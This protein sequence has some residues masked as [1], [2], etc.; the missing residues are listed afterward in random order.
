MFH[1]LKKT[2]FFKRK[3]PS[4]ISIVSGGCKLSEDL[5]NFYLTDY[6]L[7][8]HEGYGLTEASPICAWHRPKDKIKIASV[9]R[10]FPCCEIRILD[11]KNQE[12]S[13]GNVGE[14]CVNGG[15]VMKG[16][17]N[18]ESATKE[19]LIEGWLHTGD[20]GTIDHEGYVNLTGLKKRMLNVGG[21]K[22]F[23]AE[24]ERYLRRHDNVVGIEIYG[25]PD[26]FLGNV[27]KAVVRLRNRS[28]ESEE[29]FKEWCSKNI[30]KHKIPR[31]YDFTLT[32]S[33]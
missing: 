4:D 26:E 8:I 25:E 13:I 19:V 18:N 31:A 30:T 17:F 20:K 1:L 16:Y 33:V 2:N 24:L 14:I 5:F 3:K 29:S 12:A 9:G 6:G 21:N 32:K 22:V 11:E 28:H 23:P 27:V 15:N 7:S 10:S